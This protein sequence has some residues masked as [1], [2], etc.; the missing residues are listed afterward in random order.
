MSLPAQPG[1]TPDMSSSRHHPRHCVPIQAARSP[2]QACW[3]RVTPPSPALS[4]ELQGHSSSK[5]SPTRS[6]RVT[7]GPET[8]TDHWHRPGPICQQP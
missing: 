4:P 5:P 3:L 1:L 6:M 2:V 8:S 7:I